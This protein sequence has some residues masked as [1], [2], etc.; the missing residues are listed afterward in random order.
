M[1][2]LFTLHTLVGAVFTASAA[3][4]QNA[5]GDALAPGAK[6]VALGSS[7]AA[8]PGVPEQ[9]GACGRSSANYPHLVA[10]ALDLELT[11]VTC[12]GATTDHILN[13]PQAESP[14]QIDAV[15]S[16]T[17][18]VTVT[19]GGNDITF[20][21]STFAC[22]GKPASERCT[23]N[24]DQVMINNALELLPNKLGATLDAIKARA[25]Q[26]IIV[27]VTYPRIFL[28]D[29]ESCSELEL[30]G[31]DT[32]Y[33][34]AMG[35]KLQDAFVNVVASR[36]ALIA[37]SYVL[38]EGHGPCESATSDR[39]VNGNKIAA[40]GIRYH[41]TAEGHVEMARLV[42]AALGEAGRQ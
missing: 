27:L 35:Q 19:I 12:S 26:A 13:T 5:P 7:F 11:D 37:D 21:S 30:S 18:L 41:P 29:A 24:L 38:A 33:F 14:L 17:T 20:T 1:N 32:A 31:E 10:D 15:T 42:V 4:S 8:G 34:A 40:S 22:A 6:Y 2:A 9:L 28:P 25:P 36:Q 39:W 23:A 16:D 3:L